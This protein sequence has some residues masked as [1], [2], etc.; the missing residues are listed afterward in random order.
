MYISTISPPRSKASL[1][2]SGG[3]NGQPNGGEV[4]WICR[5]RAAIGPS[6][7]GTPYANPSGSVSTWRTTGPTA[8]VVAWPFRGGASVCRSVRSTVIVVEGT[9]PTQ[10][11]VGRTPPTTLAL[12]REDA[13]RSR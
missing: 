7:I 1:S 9:G 13:K 2:V 12:T 5:M 8:N 11:R 6:G 4:G 3:P 10:V